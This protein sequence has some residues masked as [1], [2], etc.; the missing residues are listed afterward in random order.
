MLNI[1]H[2]SKG[3]IFYFGMP[4]VGN[5]SLIKQKIGFSSGAVNYYQKK[6]LCDIAAVTKSFYDNWD[7]DAYK[8]YLSLFSLDEK[9]AICELS[10]GMKVKSNLLLAL[11]PMP[12]Y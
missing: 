8:K 5:E 1:V 3:E 2:P 9:K 7:D 6:K 10:E 12:K 4:F 11:S